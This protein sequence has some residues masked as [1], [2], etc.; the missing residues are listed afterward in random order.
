MVSHEQQLVALAHGQDAQ[1]QQRQTYEYEPQKEKLTE[2][3]VSLDNLADD[4]QAT[5]NANTKRFSS[6]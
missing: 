5:S 1:N 4:T 6:L 3:G 2:A